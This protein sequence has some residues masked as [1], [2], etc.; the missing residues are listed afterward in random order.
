MRNGITGLIATGKK[1]SEAFCS[2]T[3]KL[4]HPLQHLENE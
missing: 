1:C 4:S 3:W 2:E